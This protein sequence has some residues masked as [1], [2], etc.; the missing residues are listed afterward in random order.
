MLIWFAQRAQA[1]EDFFNRPK[2]HITRYYQPW[3]CR[4]KCSDDREPRDEWRHVAVISRIW[5]N[6]G[7]LKSIFYFEY[8]SSIQKFWWI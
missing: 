2:I 7:K 3:A 1:S 8:I 6:E 5:I 4:L